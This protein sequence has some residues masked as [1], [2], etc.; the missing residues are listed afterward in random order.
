MKIEIEAP[1][2]LEA[3]AKVEGA[4]FV[5]IPTFYGKDDS[6]A[7]VAMI[8]VLTDDGTEVYLGQLQ[9]S[10]GTGDVSVLN[11]SAKVVSKMDKKNSKTKPPAKGSGLDVQ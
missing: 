6:K 3:D 4:K 1:S 11:R 9:V 7:T 5:A 8:R 10:G 2:A